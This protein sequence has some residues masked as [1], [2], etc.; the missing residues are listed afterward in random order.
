MARVSNDFSKSGDSVELADDLAL[1]ANMPA[2]P[3]CNRVKG[4]STLE[5]FRKLLIDEP[6]VL[7][8]SQN[9]DAYKMSKAYGLIKRVY[10]TVVFYF[11]T[12]G[13]NKQGD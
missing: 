12:H 6:R 3:D 10:K 1:D 13:E 8:T 7:E 5:G 11:E 2:C 4:S 9:Y